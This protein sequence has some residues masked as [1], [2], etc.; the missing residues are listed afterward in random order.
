VQ[1]GAGCKSFNLNNGNTLIRL[2]KVEVAG[3]NPVSRSILPLDFLELTFSGKG[4]NNWAVHV[5]S[6]TVWVF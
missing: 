5:K 1:D 6:P 4:D 3:S 2:A